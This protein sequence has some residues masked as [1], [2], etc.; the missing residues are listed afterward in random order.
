MKDGYDGEEESLM[1]KLEAEGGRVIFKKEAGSWWAN[2]EGGALSYRVRE[3]SADE[4]LEDSP[5]SSAQGRKK[6]EC[7]RGKRK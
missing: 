6:C 7:E 1:R 4:T 5:C 3:G 2:D